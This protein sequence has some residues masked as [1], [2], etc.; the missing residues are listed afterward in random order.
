MGSHHQ[1]NSINHSQNPKQSSQHRRMAERSRKRRREAR[2]AHAAGVVDG[3][4]HRPINRPAAV[5]TGRRLRAPIGNLAPKRGRVARVRCDDHAAMKRVSSG[6]SRRG[7]RISGKGAG[8]VSHSR[9]PTARRVGEEE[10]L[11]AGTP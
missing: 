6:S 11:V 4:G 1:T 9:R 5:G 8:R 7:R 2:L 10:R 3:R